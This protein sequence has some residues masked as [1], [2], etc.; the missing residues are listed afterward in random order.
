MILV[1]FEVVVVWPVFTL[2]CW[3]ISSAWNWTMTRASKDRPTA[4][5]IWFG[6]CHPWKVAQYPAAVLT[7]F[8]AVIMLVVLKYLIP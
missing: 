6:W 5:E 1:I 3:V 2:L 8:H 7:G 4:R